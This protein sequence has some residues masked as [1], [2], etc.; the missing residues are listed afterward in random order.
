MIAVT[1]PSERIFRGSHFQQIAGAMRQ[2]RVANDLGDSIPRPHIFQAP[3]RENQTICAS[4]D[5]IT[6]DKGG[7]AIKD[8]QIGKHIARSD[9]ITKLYMIGQ[10]CL[11]YT[12][13]SPRDL[14]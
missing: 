3:Q 11:L 2:W 6:L 1:M 8:D 12:S 13:P 14:H 4:P 9:D 7:G 10:N 5:R